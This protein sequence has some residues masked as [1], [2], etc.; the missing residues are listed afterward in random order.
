MPIRKVKGLSASDRSAEDK[1][2]IELQGTDFNESANTDSLKV[3]RVSAPYTPT[4]ISA[5]P[6]IQRYN[7]SLYAG[8]KDIKA[9]YEEDYQ[10]DQPWA[11]HTK[12]ADIKEV[13]SKVS[14]YYRKYRNTDYITFT[15]N[16]W[17]KISADYDAR[18]AVYGEQQ[19][20]NWLQGQ[21]QDNV[22]SNQG[23]LEKYGNAF[24]GLGASTAGALV[25]GYGN[26]VGGVSYL[27][28]AGYKTEG[29]NGWQNFVNNVMDNDITRY[30]DD[31]VKYGSW[32]PE[33]IEI[34]KT[35]YGGISSIPILATEKQQREIFN[36]NTIPEALAQGGFTAATMLMGVGEAKI[37]SRMFRGIKKATLAAKTG[38]TL[39]NLSDAK[40][41]LSAI[42]KAEKA[43]YAIALPAIAGTHEGLMEG[44]NTKLRVLENAKREL[45]QQQ[46]HYVTERAKQL[47]AENPNMDYNSARDV[48][49]NEYGD[50]YKESLDYIEAIAS[51]AGINNFYANSAINGVLNAT[52]KAG[53]QAPTVQGALQKSKLTSWAFPSGKFNATGT[54]GNVK[55]TPKFNEAKQVFNIVKEPFG[56]FTEEYLQ[57]ISDAAMSGAGEYSISKFIEN[58]YNGESVAEIGDYMSGSFAAGWTALTESLTDK[59]TIKSGVYGAISSALGTF[60]PSRSTTKLDAKGNVVYKRNPDGSLVRDKRGRPIAETVRFGRGQNAKGE[61]ESRWEAFS[62]V[63]PW[64]SGLYSQI[65]A[66]RNETERLNKE[67]GLIEDWINN[68]KN[69]DKFDG[70]VGT[71]SWVRDM[72][73][74]ASI[75]DEFGYRNS[76]LGKTI[77]DALI[78]E[79]LKGTAFYDSYMNNL[80]IAANSERGSQEAID[81]VN[82]VRQDANI[83]SDFEGMTDD[84]V[85][86][87]IK[88]NANKMLNTINT[89]QQESDNIERVLGN[90]DED[91]KISLIYGKMALDDWNARKPKLDSEINEIVQGIENTVEQSNLTQKQKES[92]ATFG[93]FKRAQKTVEKMK[94]EMESL[95]KDIKNLESRRGNIKSEEEILKRKKAKYSSLK[96]AVQRFSE[97]SADYAE[98]DNTVLNESEILSL[99][100][101]IRAAMLNPDNL[102]NYSEAQ[103]EVIKNIINRGTAQDINFSSKMQDSGRL[104]AA[105]RTYL[106]QYNE[107]LTNPQAFNNYVARQREAAN[108]VISKKRYESLSQITDYTQFAR[109][110]DKIYDTSTQREQALIESALRRNNNENF[111]RYEQQRTT[112]NNLVMQILEDEYFKDM[113][114][115]DINLFMHTLTYLSDR[116][117]DISNSSQGSQVLMEQDAQGNFL[118]ESYI[119]EVNSNIPED[120]RV[121]FTSIGQVI[122][123]YVDALNRNNKDNAER[124]K[125]E[126]PIIV[127]DTPTEDSKPA[128]PV[129]VKIEDTTPEIVE[130]STP[131]E[132]EKVDSP[133]GETVEA[134]ENT[135][136]TTANNLANNLPRFSKNARGI[137]QSIINNASMDSNPTTLAEYLNSEANRLSISSANTSDFEAADL[138]RQ[139]ATRIS[140]LEGKSVK[141]TITEEKQPNIFD[142]SKANANA[143]ESLDMNY[144]TNTYPNGALSRFYK[145]YKIAEFL[146]SDVLSKN[147]PIVFISDPQLVSEVREEMEAS[148]KNYTLSALPIVAAVEVESGGITIGDKHYQP[149]AIMPATDNQ[150]HSGAARL[151]NIRKNAYRQSDEAQVSLIK[152]E[153]GEVITTSMYGNV[154][155]KAPNHLPETEANRSAHT[156]QINDLESE[157]RDTL[158]NLSKP[159]RRKSPIY[160]RLKTTFLSR[161]KVVNGQLVY[162]VPNLK[163]EVIPI[164]A[165]IT[166]VQRTIDKNSDK[167]IAELFNDNDL[168]VLNANSRLNRAAKTLV[169]FFKNNFNT[170]DFAFEQLEDGSVLPTEQTLNKLN[171]YSKQLGKKLGNFLNLP[172]RQ[173]WEY[174]ITPTNEMLDNRR[175]FE[176]AIVDNDGNRIVLGNVTKGTMSESTQLNILKN[177]IMDESGNVRMRDSKSSFVIWNVN[178]NDIRNEETTAK[179]NMSDIYDDDIIDFSKDSLEYTIK[180]VV[181]NAPF[182]LAGESN[183]YREK[184]QNTKQV[185]NPATEIPS[186]NTTREGNAIVD[187]DTGAVVE[188][189]TSTSNDTYKYRKVEVSKSVSNSDIAPDSFSEMQS[190]KDQAIT[191]GTFMKAPN[192]KPTNLNERQWLQVRTK[193][194]K[195]WFGDWENDPANASKVVD[196]NGEPM[197]MTHNTTA[198]PF[199]VFNTEK[200]LGKASYFANALAIEN[201][202]VGGFV[203]GNTNISTFLN[204]R[205][206]YESIEFTD[207]DDAREEGYD[208]AIISGDGMMVAAAF[209][210]N[211][212]KSSTDNIGTFS[213]ENNN[214]YDRVQQN[215]TREVQETKPI[216]TIRDRR[217]KKPST[218]KPKVERT[219]PNKFKWGVFEGAN[220]SVNEITEALNAQGIT[221]EEQWNNRTDEEM[222]RV[223]H[224]CGA[225]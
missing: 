142:Q 163:G 100:S 150:T 198:N 57:S 111:A 67:A 35:L 183:Y 112:L 6:A 101:D 178:Y 51:K 139:I 208:G 20:N 130:D 15:P 83:S 74:S 56:E 33:Q 118:V 175:L 63:M 151:S 71:A 146:R 197:V 177:L 43:T 102:S 4:P 60:G 10:V 22:A 182:T 190:I 87:R 73:S 188:G 99:P 23:V 105:S 189:N 79:K 159:D 18:K 181:I 172:S 158:T 156:L 34:N 160:R 223:L 119:N 64:R 170:E 161:L 213:K 121:E 37:A 125:V 13:A 58:K 84:Q 109:E 137:A 212:I 61:L 116:G 162:E 96:K 95:E 38:K 215:E 47:V 186:G 26:L 19:A 164:S 192:G 76:V 140:N 185:S 174:T 1:R 114:E 106:T 75:S 195:N 8:Y 173:G 127:E 143:I 70:A 16:D 5:I 55:V 65:K 168:S 81:I 104:E 27:V 201:G 167:T 218:T 77:N 46:E 78:L 216:G 97:E 117:V 217:K 166:P 176:L 135:T 52:L 103:Q 24:L 124:E 82:S 53:L 41:A 206:P 21:I 45:A 120:E 210:P 221:T 66:I 62:R 11:S 155:A 25:S 42:Q 148:G 123:T 157:D 131:V 165:F 92:I 90:V 126:Q 222:E 214:I 152:D 36:V 93:S 145:K 80:V 12:I 31:I 2:Q 39:D 91:T 28:G 3:P 220:I 108:D 204:I 179:N 193:A 224:C 171:E 144:I 88:A 30:G 128:E 14:P 211:Q 113:D 110:L 54:P 136:I 50:K 86:D 202:E 154:V 196:E 180:G 141:E 9:Q 89:I 203:K 133:Q 187:T 122:Q 32:R 69:K 132:E 98:V 200:S 48:A 40:K 68:P 184:V 219:I 107:I 209:S 205:N 49:F 115:N 59:E 29:L 7:E 169:S 199:D 225:I 134:S 85:L 72:S 153:N 147:S 149:I 191:N 138:L 17:A 94:A 194:F 207:F 129:E 44:L